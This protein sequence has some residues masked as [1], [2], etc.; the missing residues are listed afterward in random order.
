MH[1]NGRSRGSSTNLQL[2]Y[3]ALIGVAALALGT[4]EDQLQQAKLMMLPCP[5]C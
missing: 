1:E 3:V 4:T 2:M 5:D